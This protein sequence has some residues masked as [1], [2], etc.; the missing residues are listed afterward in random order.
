MRSLLNLLTIMHITKE[1]SPLH[2]TQYKTELLS[3]TRFVMTYITGARAQKN[4]RL[5]SAFFHFILPTVYLT[6]QEIGVK[7]KKV[8]FYFICKIFGNQ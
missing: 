3:Y 4:F 7:K 1:R 6:K 5:K 8:R 2:L